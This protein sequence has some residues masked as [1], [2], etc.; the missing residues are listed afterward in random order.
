MALRYILY[1]RSPIDFYR[2]DVMDLNISNLHYLFPEHKYKPDYDDIDSIF[3]LNYYLIGSTNDAI[4]DNPVEKYSDT[5][6]EVIGEDKFKYKLKSHFI[7]DKTYDLYRTRSIPSS[8]NQ[9]PKKIGRR[10]SSRWI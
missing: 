6:K 2:E 5:I 3:N 10:C 1:R 4:G 7:T 8:S 9:D